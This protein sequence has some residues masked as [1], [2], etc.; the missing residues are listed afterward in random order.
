MRRVT[1][2]TALMILALLSSLIMLT[3]PANSETSAVGIEL[4][5][6]TSIAIGSTNHYVLTISGGPAETGGVWS[7]NIIPIYENRTG[8]PKVEPENKSSDNNVFHFNFT[9]PAAVQRVKLKIEA[10]SNN[11]TDTET[12]ERIVELKVVKPI[13]IRA[14]VFNEGEVSV[15][16]A[17]VLFYGNSKLIGTKYVDVPPHANRTL[18]L[19]YTTYADGANKVTIKIDPENEILTLAGGNTEIT[20]TVYYKED[21]GKYEGLYQFFVVVLALMLLWT[22]NWTR[23]KVRGY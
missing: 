22:A 13:V 6:D 2:F 4:D 1:V 20:K 11:A 15:D 10:E 9:A 21:A 18:V 8:S 23:K 16:Q 5:G 3:A 17:K 12:A 19:N 14:K 7:Y